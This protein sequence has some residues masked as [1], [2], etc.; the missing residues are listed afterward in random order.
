MIELSDKIKEKALSL[1][2]EEGLMLIDELIKSLNLP[3]NPDIDQ[4]WKAE[5]EK[6][7]KELD[8]GKV[9]SIEGEQVFDEIRKKLIYGAKYA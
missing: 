9:K 6:R 2:S 8:Q 7:V 5:A 3:T 1:P 4:K